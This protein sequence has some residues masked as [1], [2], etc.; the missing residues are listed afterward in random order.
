MAFNP[1]ANPDKCF[2][3]LPMRKLRDKELIDYEDHTVNV[4]AIKVILKGMEWNRTKRP[5]QNYTLWSVYIQQ[6]C[7]ES[8]QWE[9]NSLF[10]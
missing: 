8:I 10:N 9:K 3:I 2:L 6:E 5:K 7:Q 1:N 4:R